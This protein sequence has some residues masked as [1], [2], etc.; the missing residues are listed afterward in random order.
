MIPINEIA[1]ERGIDEED[2]YEILELFLD[3]T[4]TE[5]LVTL[6]AALEQGNHALA[7]ERAHSIKGAALNLKL[8][9][10]ASL[11]RDVEKKCDASDVEGIDDLL[12]A[13]TQQLR[14]VKDVLV[15][16]R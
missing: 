14:E 2:V 16:Q 9:Q 15:R 4:Q 11:A 3:Y 7:R 13:I 8:V 1:D 5:D 10:I 12:N 6:K